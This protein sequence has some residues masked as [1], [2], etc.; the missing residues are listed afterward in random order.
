M[1]AAIV[2][3]P[4]PETLV[5]PLRGRERM[6]VVAAGESVFTLSKRYAITPQDLRDVNA[7]GPRYTLRPGQKLIIPAADSRQPGPDEFRAV[8][9]EPVE[10]APLDAPAP[11]P[12]DTAAPSGAPASGLTV[13]APVPRPPSVA[14]PP[15]RPV[16]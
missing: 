6:H 9:V 2:E 3:E 8:P 14:P 15:K 5:R 10:V 7:L 16:R 12:G 11:A 13:A 1:V 4:R